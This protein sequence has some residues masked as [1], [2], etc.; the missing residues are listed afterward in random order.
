MYPPLNPLSLAQAAARNVEVRHVAN[1]RH[2]STQHFLLDANKIVTGLL[3][4]S[5][6]STGSSWAGCM[7]VNYFVPARGVSLNPKP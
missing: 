5:S 3:S 4:Q 1:A 2:F 7:F 6:V